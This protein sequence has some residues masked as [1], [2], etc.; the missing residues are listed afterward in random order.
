MQ[1]KVTIEDLPLHKD[2]RGL[3]V[4]PLQANA[5]PTQRNVHVVLTEPGAIRGNHY[6]VRGTEVVTVIG[7]ALVRIKQGAEVTD[8]LVPTAKA[9]RFTIPPGTSHAI[10]NTGTGPSLLVAFNT[11]VHDP[12]RPDVVR[13]VILE[14]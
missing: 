12:D 2:V 13:D 8:T 5:L 3:V 6:H 10:Q 1:P 7:P 9:Y 4:E 14:G 11:E